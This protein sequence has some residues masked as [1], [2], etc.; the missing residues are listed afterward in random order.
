MEGLPEALLWA[1]K[2]GTGDIDL[3]DK[4]SQKIQTCKK[5]PLFQKILCQGIHSFPQGL[6]WQVAGQGSPLGCIGQEAPRS[7]LF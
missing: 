2:A 6:G 4:P 3:G 7:W 5:D 1:K